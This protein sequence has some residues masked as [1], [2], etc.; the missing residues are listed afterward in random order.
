M[1]LVAI[2]IGIA[3]VLA[4]GIYAVAPLVLFI[5]FWFWQMRSERLSTADQPG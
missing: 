1:R 3:L 4:D 5:G 2:A